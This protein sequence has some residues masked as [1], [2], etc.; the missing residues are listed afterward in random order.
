MNIPTCQAM[1]D[2]RSSLHKALWFLKCMYQN[3]QA[4]ATDVSIILYSH[5]VMLTTWVLLSQLFFQKWK[6][7][8]TLF[9]FVFFRATTTVKTLTIAVLLG[10]QL[11]S[12]NEKTTE[13]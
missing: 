4:G 3:Y 13:C 12:C 6:A 1:T 8:N 2:L 10:M 11:T 5:S 7:I 9:S